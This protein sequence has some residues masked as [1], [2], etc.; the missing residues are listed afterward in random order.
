MSRIEEIHRTQYDGVVFTVEY[1]AHRGVGAPLGT[2]GTPSTLTM[3]P[4]HML[5][6]IRGWVRADELA[7]GDSLQQAPAL[8]LPHP[9]WTPSHLRVTKITRGEYSGIVYNLTTQDHTYIAGGIV[10]HNCHYAFQFHVDFEAER[11]ARLN[12]L[13]NMRSADLALGVPFNIASYA[14][15]T[16]ICSHLTGLAAGQ[17][18]ITMADCHV[19]SNHL[20]GL[21]EQTAREPRRFPTVE[22]LT[23]ARSIDDIAWRGKISDFRIV[24]YMPMPAVVYPMS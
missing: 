14:L 3:T 21:R 9:T 4:G 19:Y 18:T 17:L 8:L 10:A 16:H 15:L 7:V 24:D 22:I 23:T 2:L 12:C 5:K 6:T 11:P 1:C 13:V 20:E